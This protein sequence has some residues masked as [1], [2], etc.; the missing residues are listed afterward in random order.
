MDK[1]IFL[2]IGRDKQV[3][4][5]S[6]LNSKGDDILSNLFYI[7]EKFK[8]FEHNI[9][10]EK[11]L[12]CLSDILAYIQEVLNGINENKRNIANNLMCTYRN[13]VIEKAK[14]L[15]FN[16]L[17]NSQQLNHMRKLMD[18]FVD[19][20]FDDDPDFKIIKSKIDSEYIEE[21]IREITGKRLSDFNA[22]EKAWFKKLV[23]QVFKEDAKPLRS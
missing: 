16:S 21:S 5:A 8:E 15:L 3:F 12:N 9:D 6:Y 20:D 1:Q 4:I 23:E 18:I 13:K 14:G 22:E 19:N 7:R 11:G 10:N 17:L 2:I